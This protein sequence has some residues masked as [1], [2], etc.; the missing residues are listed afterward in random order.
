MCYASR[1]WTWRPA[2]QPAPPDPRDELKRCRQATI[3]ARRRHEEELVILGRLQSLG[4]AGGSRGNARPQ[5]ARRLTR[6]ALSTGP[7]VALMA[8]LGDG[9]L[10]RRAEA[11]RLRPDCARIA[12][13]S[14]QR[15]PTMRS[16]PGRTGT[17][18]AQATG[19]RTTPDERDARSS[20]RTAES[21]EKHARQPV[22]AATIEPLLAEFEALMA[23]ARELDS[24]LQGFDAFSQ[25]NTGHSFSDFRQRYS[26]AR[27]FR[28]IPTNQEE[29]E[30]RRLPWTRFDNRLKANPDAEFES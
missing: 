14:L 17:S 22:I 5:F 1:A 19:P 6:E 23:R 9:E 2:L 8:A 21:N 29:R 13:G 16:P 25:Y 11:A 3:E 10:A 27:R 24:D 20:L 15:A 12:Q 26:A 4:P 28:D 30:R 7:A 18:Q